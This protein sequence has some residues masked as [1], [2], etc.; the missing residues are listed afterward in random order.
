MTLFVILLLMLIFVKKGELVLLINGTHTLILDMVIKWITHLGDG[1][2]FLVLLM[3]AV[4]NK[5]KKFAYRIILVFIVHGLIVIVLKHFFF[6][7]VGRPITFF[8]DPTLLHFVEGVKVH[9]SK[10]FPSGHTATAFAAAVV[11]SFMY[12]K[13]WVIMVTLLMAALVGMSRM[14]LLQHFYVDVVVGGAIGFVVSFMICL[15]PFGRTKAE[16]LAVWLRFLTALQKPW[17]TTRISLPENT[18]SVSQTDPSA[19]I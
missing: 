11:L 8:D 15:A 6:A 3:V 7:D 14:Y 9:R 1:L 2:I 17:V 10:S 5:R 18:K 16:I 13:T 4:I 12:R 19:Q